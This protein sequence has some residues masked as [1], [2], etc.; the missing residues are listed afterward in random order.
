MIY[1]RLHSWEK[2]GCFLTLAGLILLLML[3]PDLCLRAYFLYF[4]NKQTNKLIE[5]EI[6]FVVIRGG[7]GVGCRQSKGTDIQLQDNQ[8]LRVSHI[9]R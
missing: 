7:E 4:E 6:R 5:K 8:V 1:R 2:A 3:N 9:I